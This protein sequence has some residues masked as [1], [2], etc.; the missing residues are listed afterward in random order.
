[1]QFN[2]R[3]LLERF[4]RR[5]RTRKP[6]S[7]LDVGCGN[8]ALL[9]RLRDDGIDAAGA[10]SDVDCIRRGEGRGL[11][12]R[13]A[14][15]D[16]LPFTEGAFEWVTIR[17]V[18]HHLEAPVAAVREALRVAGKG[19]MIAE[20]WNDPGILS[21]QFMSRIDACWRDLQQKRGMVHRPNFTVAEILAAIGPGR[22]PEVEIFLPLRTLGSDDF[23]AETRA[24]IGP[25]TPRAD[26]QAELADL[27]DEVARGA[28]TLP[29]T[30][31]VTAWK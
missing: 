21:Q 18:L 15:A 2:R 4:L 20:P 30:A 31:I 3:L 5:L 29:G 7:V 16:A 1:M 14:S 24:A 8:G 10:E 28:V 19:V 12:I 6:A 17:H 22:H 27:R 23:D 11:A 26:Q 9:E 13:A 25:G